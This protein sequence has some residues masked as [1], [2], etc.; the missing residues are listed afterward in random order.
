M[1]RAEQDARLPIDEDALRSHLSATDW[2]V[3]TGLTAEELSLWVQEA[4]V[5]AYRKFDTAL[6]AEIKRLEEVKQGVIA[7]RATLHRAVNTN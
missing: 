4:S 6:V 5:G 3:L 7:A 1:T 2:N